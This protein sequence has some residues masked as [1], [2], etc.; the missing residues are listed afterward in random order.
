[1]LIDSHNHIGRRKGLTFLVDDLLHEMDDN[2]IDKA[3]VFS[4]AESIDNLYVA[5][6]VKQ[7]ADRLIGFTM[8]NPWRDD[9][10][11]E[12]K[13]FTEEYGMKGLKLH[14]VKHGFMLDDHSLLDPI[15][16]LCTQYD[17]C[18]MAY[19]AADVSSIPNHFGEMARTF[20]EI[21]F[22]MAHMGYMYDTN[23]AI[24]IANEIDNV[25]LETSGVFVRAVQKAIAKAGSEKIIFGTD[26]P[27]EEISFS[28]ER[29]Y[30]ATNDEEERK[31]IL[32][33]NI[34]N[35]LKI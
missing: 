12:I 28:L 26:T 22:I 10:E 27:K 9:A 35:L 33:E 25:F 4:M 7:H 2:H 29:I 6:S 34:R 15:F 30:I 21:P 3:V 1:M 14:P 24:E 19:A 8:I 5:E 13:R 23:S 31:K 20:P 17:L 32:G 18:V 11:T 16:Q